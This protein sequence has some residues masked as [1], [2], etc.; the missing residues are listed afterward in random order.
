[1]GRG[2]A[3]QFKRAFPKNFS[4]YEAACKRHEVQPGRMLVVETGQLAAPRYIVNFPTKRHWRGDSRLEDI[5]AGLLAL[6]S[7]V[8]RREIRSIAIP[9]LGCGLGGLA[10]STVR[11]LIE[12]AFEALP[13]VRVL[14]FEPAGAPSIEHIAKS[15]DAPKMTPGRAVLV[16]LMERYLAGLLE[17]FVTLLEVH[18]LLYFIQEAGEPLRLR[19][20][21]APYGPYAENLR[22]VL[23]RIEGHLV[24][25]YADG[26]DAP[27]KQLA[28]VPGAVED[29][30]TFLAGH[31]NSR[32]RFDRVVSLVEGFETP[33]GMELL[34]TVHWVATYE[35][36]LDNDAVIRAVYAW[37]E[38]KH[39]FSER[40]I[41]LAWDLLA[42]KG[43]LPP[44]TRAWQQPPR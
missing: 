26:G 15:A 13:T 25:G 34:S 33:F 41:R 14:L 32:T 40:Q 24:S 42:S 43:W 19:Y 20:V 1:M 38:R 36:A 7:E 18:K 28:L 2:I 17:P 21:K 27:D 3:A 9:P 29:A 23:A 10:W 16:C 8:K 37:N 4:V 5:E 12:R 11:P 22:Q 30:T 44:G 39:R 31:P 35:H 6:V